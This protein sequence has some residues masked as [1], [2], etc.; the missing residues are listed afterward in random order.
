[1]AS[2]GAAA[3]DCS[4]EALL[5]DAARYPVGIWTIPEVAFVGLTAEAARAPPHNMEVR[6]SNR[7]PRVTAPPP[8]CQHIS[9]LRRL[10]RAGTAA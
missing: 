8:F 1:M 7:L 3:A 4:P 5:A 2:T 9:H 10:F 6:A